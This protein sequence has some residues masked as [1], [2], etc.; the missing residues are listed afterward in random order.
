MTHPADLQAPIA[1]DISS[2]N[3][4]PGGCILTNPP[5]PKSYRSG[6][7]FFRGSLFPNKALLPVTGRRARSAFEGRAASTRQGPARQRGD[8]GWSRGFAAG[9]SSCSQETSAEPTRYPA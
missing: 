2:G 8:M 9:R 4:K 1:R 3:Q 6:R 7:P 5:R